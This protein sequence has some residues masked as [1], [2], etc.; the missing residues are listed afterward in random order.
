M[1]EAL[2]QLELNRSVPLQT[3]LALWLVYTRGREQ[4]GSNTTTRLDESDPTSAVPCSKKWR[5]T[6][7]NTGK[8]AE[9]HKLFPQRTQ[10]MQHEDDLRTTLTF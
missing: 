10:E 6:R 3:M 2:V 7:N 9:Q 8:N 4:Q 1:A 5:N